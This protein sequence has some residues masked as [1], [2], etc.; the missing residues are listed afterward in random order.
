MF[1]KRIPCAGPECAHSKWS[2]VRRATH[3]THEKQSSQKALGLVRFH[4]ICVVSGHIKKQWDSSWYWKQAYR[5]ISEL[6][7]HMFR[8]RRGWKASFI[9]KICVQMVKLLGGV[10]WQMIIIKAGRADSAVPRSP[11]GSPQVFEMSTNKTAVFIKT[12]QPFC[13]LY[14]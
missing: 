5:S 13:Y 14:N 9:Y 12:L 2:P 10:F 8:D 7:E 4:V 1:S 3:I 11:L 6:V